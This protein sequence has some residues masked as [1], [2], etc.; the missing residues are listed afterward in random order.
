[1]IPQP[2][3]KDDKIFSKSHGYVATVTGLTDKGFTY[4]LDDPRVLVARWGWIQHGGEVYETGFADW[5]LFTG[6]NTT[7][8]LKVSFGP[9]M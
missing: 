1:M 8:P 6:S 5:E 9:V 7:V 4:V 3:S 2:F